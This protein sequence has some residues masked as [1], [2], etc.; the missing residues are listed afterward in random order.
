MAACGI[1]TTLFK[2]HSVRGAITTALIAAGI[3]QTL[4]RQRGGWSDSRAFDVHYARLHQLVAWDSCLPGGTT[5]LSSPQLPLS[6]VGVEC[7]SPVV[8]SKGCLRKPKAQEAQSLSASA[9]CAKSS[10]PEPTKEGEGKEDKH[11]S[12]EALRLL[13]VRQLV[14]PLGGAGIARHVLAEWQV[15]RS[16]NA[17][18]ATTRSMYGV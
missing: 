18:F 3:D 7:S 11:K 10:A 6:G 5:E 9:D 17:A 4:T 15:K 12:A 16:T 14:C 2:P 8:A 1:D 13:T